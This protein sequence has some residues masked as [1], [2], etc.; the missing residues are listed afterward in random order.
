MPYKGVTSFAA[1]QAS[2]PWAGIK[3]ATCADFVAKS[4]TTLSQH[5]YSSRFAAMLQNMFHVFVAP[6]VRLALK[7]C[8]LLR[9][10]HIKRAYSKASVFGD[11]KK[12]VFES[13]EGQ[14]KKE[15]I[16][17]TFI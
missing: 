3:R 14:S 17:H 1:K 7:K 16:E 15:E 6:S 13:T 10:A 2:F 12:V 9:F 11:K 5:R 8:L 4:R